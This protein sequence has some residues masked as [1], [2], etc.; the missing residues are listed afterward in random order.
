MSLDQA[1]LLMSALCVIIAAV[2]AWFGKDGWGWMILLAIC[3]APNG[4]NW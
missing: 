4:K 1:L 2:L 3:F